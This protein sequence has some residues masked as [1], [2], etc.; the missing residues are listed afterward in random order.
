[1]RLTS[2]LLMSCPV[3]PVLFICF[4]PGFLYESDNLSSAWHCRQ[5]TETHLLVSGIPMAAS[6]LR[7]VPASG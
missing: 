1:M 7:C 4:H 3:P 2:L 6:V 5:N